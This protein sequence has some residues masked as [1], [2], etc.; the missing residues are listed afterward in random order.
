MFARLLKRICEERPDRV[1]NL[2]VKALHDYLNEHGIE[3]VNDAG[4]G[5]W[6]LTGDGHLTDQT[7]RIMQQAVQASVANIRDPQLRA[8]DDATCFGRVWRFTPKLTPASRT[9]V[10][11]LV[12][13][14]TTPASRQLADA[15]PVLITDQVDELIDV[16]VNQEHKLRPA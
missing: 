10:I 1:A 7:K 13:Q 12:P 9:T 2:A 6:Q 4:D 15:A 16:L 14:F 8:A 5:P 11:N 3:V